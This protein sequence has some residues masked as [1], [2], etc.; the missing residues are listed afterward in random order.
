MAQASKSFQVIV[1]ISIY[2][3]V[4]ICP[5]VH[6][7]VL[8]CALISVLQLFLGSLTSNGGLEYFVK[9]QAPKF[10]WAKFIWASLG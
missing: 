7:G 1:L 4:V 6:G 10:K 8:S 5:V 3:Y 9:R 2:I